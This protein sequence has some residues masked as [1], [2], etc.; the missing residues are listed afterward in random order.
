MVKRLAT[1]V[2]LAGGRAAMLSKTTIPSST[3]DRY[4]RGETELP[5]SRLAELSQA[6]GVTV[7]WIIFGDDQRSKTVSTVTRFEND[8]VLLIPLLNVVGSAGFGKVNSGI[9]EIRQIPFS[10]TLLR[11]FGVS[12]ENAHFITGQG[13]SMLPTIKDGQPLLIDVGAK[14]V[15]DGGIYAITVGDDL[16]IKRIQR[17]IDGTLTLNSDNPAYRAEILSPADVDRVRLEGRV[18]WK[19]MEL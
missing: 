6:A 2:D 9:E 11:R 12:P 1:A 13:D 7:D 5:A 14:R 8:D 18:F 10:R 15:I 17:S 4:V 3:L 16:L 19:D